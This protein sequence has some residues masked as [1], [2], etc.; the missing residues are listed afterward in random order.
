MRLIMKRYFSGKPTQYSTWALAW[1]LLI[2]APCQATD[3]LQVGP[4]Y[5]SLTDPHAG[6]VIHVSAAGGSDE[7][8]DG[9]K[10]RPWKSVTRACMESGP[11]RPEKPVVIK[12]AGGEYECIDLHPLEQVHLYGGYHPDT[13]SRHLK[14]NPTVLDADKRGRVLKASEGL[15]LDG[16]IVQGGRFPGS[17]GAIYFENVYA[18]VRNCIFRNNQT[19]APDGFNQSHI[20]QVGN[21]GG[22]IGSKYSAAPLI[23]H[24][25]LDSNTTMV[26]NGGAIA[27]RYPLRRGDKRLP[28]ILNNVFLNNRT[29]LGD[30]R[31]R[32]SNGGALS[33]AD[34]TDA[35]VRGNVICAN[36]AGGRGDG[37]GLYMEHA[38]T[39]LIEKNWFVDNTRDDDGGGIYLNWNSQPVIDG[40]IFMGNRD[41][42]RLSKQ[43]RAVIKNNRFCM[44]E[45]TG[46]ICA[47]SWM[48][49][50]WNTVAEN[51]GVGVVYS[52]S[53][54]HFIPSEIHDNIIWGNQDKDLALGDYKGPAPD[55][56]DNYA[57]TFQNITQDSQVTK[58][59]FLNDGLDGKG[60][61]DYG[62][63]LHQTV[64]SIDRSGSALKENILAGRIIRMGDQWRVIHDNT[65][66]EITFWGGVDAAGKNE[67]VD[68]TIAPTFTLA[69]NSPAKGKGAD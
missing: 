11:G 63:N 26:G 32:S 48:H 53:H 36:H 24:N 64:I 1:L 19:L 66:N 42:V 17:G 43:G 25:I 68:F 14:E 56:S 10:S 39:P 51:T 21:E 54:S 40:N 35:V 44:N 46:V 34:S 30:Q 47:H 7:K 69:R 41:G 23:E 58:P 8:G 20:H 29:G 3:P 33:I 38:V 18:E 59:G 62:K 50:S 12:V 6:H 5:G 9:S 28:Q 16:F 57:R 45:G 4:R 55:V 13:W 61:L 52:N 37:G 60:T 27:I 31:T 15:I 22:A 67:T 49:F 2:T 65:V